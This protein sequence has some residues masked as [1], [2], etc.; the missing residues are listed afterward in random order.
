MNKYIDY[1]PIRLDM[2]VILCIFS[3]LMGRHSI[4]WCLSICFGFLCVLFMFQV[5]LLTLAGKAHQ[6]SNLCFSKVSVML[7]NLS[8]IKPSMLLLVC[9]SWGSCKSPIFMSLLVILV[10]WNTGEYPVFL[11]KKRNL[12]AT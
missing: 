12:S 2:I 9:A 10:S 3:I 4:F 11:V 1:Y 7:K 8:F 5:L 6:Y